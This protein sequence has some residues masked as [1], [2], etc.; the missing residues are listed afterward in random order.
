MVDVP[1][2]FPPGVKLFDVEGVPVT[3]GKI[4]GVEGL[5]VAWDFPEPRLFPM[6]SVLRNGTRLSVEAFRS[7]VSEARTAAQAGS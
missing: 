4:P 6:D 2:T 3:V 7:L 1:T 5:N